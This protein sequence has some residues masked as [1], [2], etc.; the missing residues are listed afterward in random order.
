M[1]LN[2]ANR[3]VSLNLLASIKRQDCFSNIHP[4]NPDSFMV[5]NTIETVND[6]NIL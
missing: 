6:T 5:I 1:V 4:C 3:M 2:H